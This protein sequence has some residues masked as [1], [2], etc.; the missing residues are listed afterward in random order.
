[1]GD[2]TILNALRLRSEHLQRNFGFYICFFGTTAAGPKELSHERDRS[3]KQ[4]KNGSP[5]CC[6]TQKGTAMHLH[7]SPLKIIVTD[8]PP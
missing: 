4:Q 6:K 7:S 2:G 1:M 8:A 3:G 5:P